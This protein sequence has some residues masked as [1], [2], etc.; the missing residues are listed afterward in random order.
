MASSTDDV[1]REF[2]IA[3]LEN[4]NVDRTV[5][6]PTKVIGLMGKTSAGSWEYLS[7]YGGRLVISGTFSTTT[8][9]LYADSSSVSAIQGDAGKLLVS[10]KQGD[11][12]LLRVSTIQGDAA[13]QNISAKSLD[14][15]TLLVSAK[16]GDAGLMRVSSLGTN[17]DAGQFLV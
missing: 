16:Q 9:P 11:A 13:N 6:P 2:T 5:D 12:A 14:A 15:G 4:W 3:E 1:K 8:S 7:S 10:A 17:S